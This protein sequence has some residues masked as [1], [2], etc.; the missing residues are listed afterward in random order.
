MGRI[1]R[2]PPGANKQNFLTIAHGVLL[3]LSPSSHVGVHPAGG[4]GE[5]GEPG[6][7]PVPPGRREARGAAARRRVA[8]VPVPVRVD[9][10][11]G[12][13]LLVTESCR[14]ENGQ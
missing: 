1:H 10:D 13:D 8:R 14:E 7:G 11:G 3:A 6:P 12:R 2:C 4:P 9:G 5:R